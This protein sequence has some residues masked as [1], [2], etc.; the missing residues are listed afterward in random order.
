MNHYCETIKK[1]ILNSKAKINVLRLEFDILEFIKI[2]E[3]YK[4][5]F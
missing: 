3:S 5:T 4:I 2:N 1:Q